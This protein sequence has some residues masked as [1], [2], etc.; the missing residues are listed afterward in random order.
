MRIR[1][2][3]HSTVVRIEI[4]DGDIL[5]SRANQGPQEELDIVFIGYLAGLR[6]MQVPHCIGDNHDPRARAAAQIED[7]AAKLIGLMRDNDWPELHIARCFGVVEVQV[8]ETDYSSQPYLAAKFV[9]P[10]DA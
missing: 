10:D 9:E 7:Q 5:R 4:D 6:G 1:R 2:P 8:L 3:A